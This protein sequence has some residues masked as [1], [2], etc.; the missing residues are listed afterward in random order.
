VPASTITASS[1][2][3][4][5]ATRTILDQGVASASPAFLAGVPLKPTGGRGG[6]SSAPSGTKSPCPTSD[7]RK[8]GP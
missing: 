5:R 3:V 7:D 4:H 2:G 8:E 6:K 1:G